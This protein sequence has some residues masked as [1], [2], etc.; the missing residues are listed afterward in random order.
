MKSTIVSAFILAFLSTNLAGAAP[1]SGGQPVQ[2]SPQ[3]QGGLQPQGGIQPQAGSQPQGGQQ[4]QAGKPVE[5]AVQAIGPPQKIEQYQQ[6]TKKKM[7]HPGVSQTSHKKITDRE[8]DLY[9]E[10]A[11]TK[12]MTV[13]SLYPPKPTKLNPLPDV[14]RRRQCAK[15]LVL[16]QAARI[17]IQVVLRQEARLASEV[18]LH[19]KVRMSPEV[20][21]LEALLVSE[22]VLRQEVRLA[23]EVVLYQEAR[24]LPEVALNPEVRMALVVVLS[25]GTREGRMLD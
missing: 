15:E 2:G 7:Q 25:K 14:W 5:P 16:N 11:D 18:A 8:A 9:K 13:I 12:E 17:P 22:V 20:V 3:V 6:L 23:S 24:M 4:P 19:Q 1:Q 10:I 21:L